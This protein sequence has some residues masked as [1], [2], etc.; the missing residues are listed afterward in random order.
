MTT[1]ELI[2]ATGAEVLVRF[3]DLH[4]ACRVLDSKMSYGRPRLQIEPLVGVGAQWIELSRLV[5]NTGADDILRQRT[6]DSVARIS[7]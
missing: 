5:Q 7:R 2:P 6:A 4:I 3:E 1:N